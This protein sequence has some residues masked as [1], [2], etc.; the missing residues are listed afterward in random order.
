M[1]W[2]CYS[3]PS[4][5][6]F[7]A[8]ICNGHICEY[9]LCVWY[10]PQVRRGKGCGLHLLAGRGRRWRCGGWDDDECHLTPNLRPLPAVD[11]SLSLSAPG[12]LGIIT[13]KNNIRNKNA[14]LTTINVQQVYNHNLL[15]AYAGK[16]PKFYI[17]THFVP[18]SHIKG[19]KVVSS[20]EGYKTINFEGASLT[21][22]PNPH[23]FFCA[24][25]QQL[26]K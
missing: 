11:H 8:Q 1:W 7:Q 13:R 14:L 6:N 9:L 18:G 16:C 3:D 2:I 25:T 23:F 21:L 22:Q 24:H 5:P 10:F 17:C 12:N 15:I 4:L 19:A 20:N 26:K